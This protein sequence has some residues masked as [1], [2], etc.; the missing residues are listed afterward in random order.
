MS[1][2]ENFWQVVTVA[3]RTK[4]TY[5]NHYGFFVTKGLN[6]ND[7]RGESCEDVHAWAKD[8]RPYLSNLGARSVKIVVNSTWEA[9]HVSL[10]THAE[11][12]RVR[13]RVCH[14][15]RRKRAPKGNAPPVENTERVFSGTRDISGI[16]YVAELLGSL[17][18]KPREVR[19]ERPV[20]Y[21]SECECG[22][23]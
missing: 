2:N 5:E 7:T 11:T 9:A 14:V 1:L 10:C 23:A 20:G 18:E 15:A 17:T 12:H 6:R 13:I 3:L 21:E 22:K 8:P 4:R 19:P 16:K